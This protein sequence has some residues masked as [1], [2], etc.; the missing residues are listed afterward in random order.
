MNDDF[1]FSVGS[2]EAVLNEI[3]FRF[4]HRHVVLRSALQHEARTQ[5]R[6]IG[7]AGNIEKHILWQHSRQPGENLFRAPSLTLEI[8]DIRLHED[9]AAIAEYR[10]GLSRESQ[11]GILF[12]AQT[13]SLSGRLQKISIAG[14]TLRIEFEI[15]DA[16]VVQNDDLDVLPTHVDDDVRIFVKLE[17]RFGMSDR[18]DE[19]HV[20]VQ[21]VFQNVFRVAGGRN[22]QHF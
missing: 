16:A 5:S 18:F 7:N 15:F 1:G 13:K 17:R 22:S 12:H 11:I 10:H 20:C 19:R 9:R 6:E 21:N 8:H 3:Y 4:H 14:G 2:P